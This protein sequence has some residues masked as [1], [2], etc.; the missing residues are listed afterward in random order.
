MKLYVLSCGEMWTER[1]FIWHFGTV[2]DS[3]KEYM[4]KAYCMRTSIYFINHP[5]VKILFDTGWKP[6]EMG[7]DGFP[8]RRS[9]EDGW[10]TH[11]AADE[12]PSAQLRKCGINLDDIDYVVMSHLMNE[13]A[14]WLPEFAGKKARIIVQQKEYEYARRI[15]VPLHA[16]QDPPIEQFHS[17]MYWRHQFEAP[18]LNYKLINGDYE[19]T[20][21]VQILHA[22]GHTPG[23]QV[24]LIRLPN[25]GTIVMSPCE[26]LGMY[27][28]TPING[29]G[30]GIPH[31]FTWFAAQ[32]L[33]TFHR[34]R[35]I[36]AK[37]K[38]QVFCG[39]DGDQAKTLKHAPDYY[40]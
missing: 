10:T 15:G 30:P 11:Q 9:P 40:D 20:R 37:E 39:H 38:G 14:G 4:P 27:Y 18:G 22:P 25:S 29:N 2:E 6:E 28:M 34:I 19:I 12:N 1:A 17:W 31:A 32:E 36:V 3:G 13:H 21:D 5:E 33:Q 24:M 16:G 35:K 23:Y 8:G 26:H 7:R